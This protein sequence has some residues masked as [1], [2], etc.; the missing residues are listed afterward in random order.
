MAFRRSIWLVLA[1]AQLGPLLGCSSPSAPILALPTFD[2]DALGPGRYLV[3]SAGTPGWLLVDGSA[4]SVVEVE[5]EGP[6]IWPVLS[7]DGERV[8]YRKW[9]GLRNS[10]WGYEIFVAAADGTR[11]RRVL[12]LEGSHERHPSWSPDGEALLVPTFTLLTYSL[13]L[14]R[15]DGSGHQIVRSRFDLTLD[16]DRDR[17]PQVESEAAFNH[18][19][20]MRSSDEIVLLCE[21]RLFVVQADAEREIGYVSPLRHPGSEAPYLQKLSVSPG[22]DRVALLE[23]VGT[24]GALVVV[25]LESGEVQMTVSLQASAV[26]WLQPDASRLCWSRDGER[27]HF[28]WTSGGW[29]AP[30][31]LYT[32]PATGGTPVLVAGGRSGEAS[33]DH[34]SCAT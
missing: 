23:T 22:G 1:C 12:T 20:S 7:P 14:V 34:V 24:D 6:D 9:H 15:A 17:C 2:F 26:P 5:R 32:V 13:L 25:D 16:P 28:L 30:S 19:V 27:V 4:R 10:I 29:G 11:E 18:V 33:I 3:K 31:H 8:A 21:G